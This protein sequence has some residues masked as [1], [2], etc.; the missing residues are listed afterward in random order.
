[1][2][3][4]PVITVYDA[5]NASEMLDT[6]PLPVVFTAPI[7]LDIVQFVHTNLAKNHRQPYAVKEWA[8]HQ[9]S[10]ESWGTGRAVAR[11]PRVGGS[12]TSRC[13]QGAFGNMC[14]KGRMFAPTKIWRRWHRRVNLKM[15][16]HAVAAALAASSVPALVMARGH[17]IDNVPEVP[18]VL[19]KLEK[20]ERTK[21]F[22]EVLKRF[23]AYDDVERVAE[24]KALRCGH[25]KVRN[26][27]YRIRRGPLIVYEEV[28]APVTRACRN[29]PG[30]DF[31]S[32]H[33]LN[34]LQ[35][36]PG[37]S[38]GRFVI[39]SQEAFK[40]LNGIFGTYTERGIEKKGYQLARPML[41][42]PDITSLLQSDAVQAALRPMK[43]NTRI[44]KGSRKNPLRNRGFRARL[45]PLA[46][47]R[48]R[49]DV[50][51]TKE[52]KA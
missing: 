40:A 16:R 52:H 20:V 5:N 8:G 4:R 7:R 34:I 37:G 27:R 41:L 47:L 19:A 1:M 46:K 30:V 25:G 44:G 33:K 28:N 35:L 6:V 26:R 43:K 29:L 17:R 23:G 3:A 24:S 32:V 51:S 38:L 48:K 18:L 11:I 2:A 39:W 10:A 49:M 13:A 42:Q 22:V 15:K 36:A 9:T 12:G 31:V 14:R 45:N 50:L 21:D